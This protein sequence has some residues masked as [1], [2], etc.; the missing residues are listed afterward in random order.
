MMLILMKYECSLVLLLF[1]PHTWLLLISR[2]TERSGG[3][4]Q[5]I[6]GY[7]YIFIIVQ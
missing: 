6:R 2:I 3:G 7:Y 4:Q 5:P 1:S